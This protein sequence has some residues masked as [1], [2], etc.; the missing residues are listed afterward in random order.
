MNTDKI[1]AVGV[2]LP[3]ER[4]NWAIEKS[5]RQDQVSISGARAIDEGSGRDE[6]VG[7]TIRAI[8]LYGSSDMRREAVRRLTVTSSGVCPSPFERLRQSF[9]PPGPHTLNWRG[10]D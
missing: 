4:I 8:E 5:W 3:R 2:G 7:V 10:A 6:F 1:T 9:G